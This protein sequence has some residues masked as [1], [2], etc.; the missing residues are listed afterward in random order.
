MAIKPA[1]ELET[2]IQDSCATERGHLGLGHRESLMECSQRGRHLFRTDPAGEAG[3]RE[4]SE[5][6]EKR[7]ERAKVT[8]LG[9]G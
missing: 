6:G 9:P 7:G 8:V 1:L 2:R 3:A 5:A 4:T